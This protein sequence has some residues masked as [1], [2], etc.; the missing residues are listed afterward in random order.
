MSSNDNVRDTRSRAKTIENSDRHVRPVGCK[1]FIWFKYS[2]RCL[3]RP[4][5]RRF[6]PSG[7][8]LFF[9]NFKKNT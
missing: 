6:L 1:P 4:F 3:K 5:H 9:N 8:E 7:A 2:H